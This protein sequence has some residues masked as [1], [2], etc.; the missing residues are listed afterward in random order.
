MSVTA[1]VRRPVSDRRSTAAPARRAPAR[2]RPPLQV[3]V[4]SAPPPRRTPFVGVVV[5]VLGLGLLGLLGLNTALAQ[6]A[7]HQHDLERQLTALQDE[8]QALQQR[9]ATLAA[10]HRLASEAHAL[11][12]V[13]TVDPAF[14]R[15]RDGAVLGEPTPATGAPVTVAPPPTP[16]DPGVNDP[17]G[18]T[19][20]S[21]PTSAAPGPSADP[22]T[23]SSAR[24]T[25][26][27]NGTRHDRGDQKPRSNPAGVPQDSSPSTGGQR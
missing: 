11:G 7:F 20:D 25:G 2:P 12:M 6:G 1:P 8:E 24:L 15:A 23:D 22:K 26:Q 27:G 18:R 4:P 13:A 21:G 16:P 10:P 5:G 14:L 19:P 9:V 3:V 17:R